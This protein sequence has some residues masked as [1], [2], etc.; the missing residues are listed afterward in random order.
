MHFPPVR[1][2]DNPRRHG[3]SVIADQSHNDATIANFY[4]LTIKKLNVN[5]ILNQDDGLQES[6]R[7]FDHETNIT[8][9]GEFLDDALRMKDQPIEETPIEE[10]QQTKFQT[11]KII[12]Y[13]HY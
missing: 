9:G 7:P 13:E 3:V 5:N 12:Y 4:F 11:N 8:D 1:T 10:N 6:I 2:R